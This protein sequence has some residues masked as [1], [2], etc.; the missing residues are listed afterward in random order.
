MFMKIIGFLCNFDAK[1]MYKVR[2]Q[3]GIDFK[4]GCKLNMDRICCW[5][6][7]WEV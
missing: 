6:S 3:K 1:H 5:A 7:K 4:S 2:R